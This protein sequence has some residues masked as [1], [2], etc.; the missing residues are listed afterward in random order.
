MKHVM[1]PGIGIGGRQKP[2]TEVDFDSTKITCSGSDPMTPNHMN[3][4]VP[5]SQQRRWLENCYN[6]NLT[7]WFSLK[8]TQV[9]YIIL[10]PILIFLPIILLKR[11]HILAHRGD[12]MGQNPCSGSFQCVGSMGVQLQPPWQWYTITSGLSGRVVWPPKRE[13]LHL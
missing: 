2:Q 11:W 7:C 9:F 13:W 1:I 8:T 10:Y 6:P 12:Q 4:P 3:R 5:E